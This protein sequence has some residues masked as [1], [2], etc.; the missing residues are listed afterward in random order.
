MQQTLGLSQKGNFGYSAELVVHGCKEIRTLFRNGR[1]ESD[2]T[3]PLELID[4]RP[5]FNWMNSGNGAS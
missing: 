2:C 5:Y 4:P 1:K 3:I